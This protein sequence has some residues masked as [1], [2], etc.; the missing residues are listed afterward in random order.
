MTKRRS[1]RGNGFLYQKVPGGTWYCQ[2]YD[3]AGKRITRS[4]QTADH[5]KAQGFLHRLYL[6]TGSG[7][8]SS[9]VAP[10]TS[11]PSV[12]S[13]SPAPTPS[14]ASLSEFSGRVANWAQL[15]RSLSIKNSYQRILKRLTSYMGRQTLH[16][17]SQEDIAR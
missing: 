10:V 7:G 8:S 6:A 11:T 3:P 4:T 2:I 13:L 5:D 14:G 12:L 1:R 17:V 9:A 16:E 15:Y